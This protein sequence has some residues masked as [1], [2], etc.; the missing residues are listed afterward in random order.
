LLA[1]GSN[2][3]LY[4][5]ISSL[6]GFDRI[7]APSKTIG[8]WVFALGIL[9]GMGMNQFFQTARAILWKRTR[10]VF[11]IV[12][13][14]LALG[15][16]LLLDK[17][18]VLR[19]FAPFILD[20]AIPQKMPK[21]VTIISKEYQRLMVL[22][23]LSLAFILLYVRRLL[24]RK[25]AVLLFCCLVLGDLLYVNKG[26][27]SHRDELYQWAAETKEQLD[28]TIGRDK[29]V[30][31]VGSYSFGMGANIEMYLG[32]QTV[33][34]YNAMFLRRYYEYINQYRFYKERVPTGW[35][36]FFYGDY[37]NSVLMDLLNVKYVLSYA[38]K[39]YGLRGSCLPRA[40]VVPEAEILPK[41]KV[42]DRLIDPGFDPLKTVLLE[43]DGKPLASQMQIGSREKLSPGKAHI[44]SYR[45]DEIL[46]ATDS[47]ESG[48]L[49]LS[50]SYYPGWKAYV[51]EKPVRIFRGNY[52][53]RVI[54]LPRGK[55]RV[56]FIFD[57]YTLKV[58]ACIT[59]LTLLLF[60]TG[61]IVRT[62]RSKKHQR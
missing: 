30:Y 40:F 54:P 20:E 45:P 35:I 13:C 17:S 48:Y 18:L 4:R 58:G 33:G 31:R 34:G 60:A 46:V 57:P 16:I 7:R 43:D 53:F 42:L 59:F 15:I 51:D 62:L 37:E 22:S 24:N 1:L 12:C 61:T 50:E 5:I 32:Y 6:P 29:E 23:A 2:T 11:L 56:R 28:S 55:H 21:A 52:L 3:P 25:V 27:P 14:I 26:A 10:V 36:I 8:L 49:F 38:N 47:E 39:S 41:Q 19:V 9:A 44:T